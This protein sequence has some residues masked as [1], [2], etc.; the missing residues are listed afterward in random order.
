M[1]FGD[2]ASIVEVGEVE[3]KDMTNLRRGIYPNLGVLS[4]DFASSFT[5]KAYFRW[6]FLLRFYERI[7]FVCGVNF[8][9]KSSLRLFSQKVSSYCCAKS[10]HT[11]WLLPLLSFSR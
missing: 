11:M 4:C 9:T 3:E 1:F 5:K 6:I 10:L 8:G 7:S 2:F